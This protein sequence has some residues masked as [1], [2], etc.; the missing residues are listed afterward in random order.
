MYQLPDNPFITTYLFH[1]L[2]SLLQL[3]L[4]LT[5]LGLYTSIH[6]ATLSLPIPILA[7]LLATALPILNGLSLVPYS[8]PSDSKS[9]S[10]FLPNTAFIIILSLLD[11]ILITLA[12]TYLTPQILQ[13][14]LEKTWRSSFAAKNVKLIRGVQ[15]S[16]ECCGLRSTRDQAWP[17]PDREH[18]ADACV[19]AFGR[20]RSCEGVWMGEERRALGLM[21]GVGVVCLV[22]KV[23]G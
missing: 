16:L 22:S 21:I 11:T 3:S 5:A 20:G 6:S 18:G 19:V 10:K 2:T 7:C 12:S 9:Q 4:L 1:L 13:C 17:F 15:D 8:R 14:G 23:G